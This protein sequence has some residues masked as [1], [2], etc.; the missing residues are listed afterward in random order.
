MR[1]R[2]RADPYLLADD[3]G[4]GARIDHHLGRRAARGQL[5]VLDACQQA[6]ARAGIGGC[7][8]RHGYTIDGTRRALAEGVVECSDHA[9]DGGEIVV[10]QVQGDV[11]AIGERI[12][13]GTFNRGAVGNA[14]DAGHVHRDAGTVLALRTEAADDQVALGDRVDLAIGTAQRSHQQRA[15]TQGHRIADRGHGDVDRLARLGERRQF[16]MDRHRRHVLQ[17]RVDV[18]RH[19]DAELAEQVLQAL[20]GERC[21]AGAVTAAIQA[22]HQAVAHQRIAAHA[23]DLGQVLDALG[24]GRRSHC[25]QEEE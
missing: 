19:I 21:L 7:G 25:Q 16:G 3:H 22:H 13:Q 5:Q 1:D 24:A 9:R 18:R 23:T 4:A 12:G 17:L 15:A 20:H 2:G 10:V 6:D 8:D 11:A 14:A